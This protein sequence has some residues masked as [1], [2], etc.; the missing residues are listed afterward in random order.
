MDVI[1]N[2]GLKSDTL[3]DISVVLAKQMLWAADL[4]IKS[5]RLVQSDTEPTLVVEVTSVNGPTLT[6]SALHNLSVDLGQD[7]IAVYRP[8]TKGGALVGPK[9]SA[10]GRF[11]PEFFILPDG[12]R[13]A[14]PAAQAA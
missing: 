5:E 14:A 13:L 7:C 1:L 9:A 10:W 12:T 6:L 11:N 3:G 2:I 4:L 8:K